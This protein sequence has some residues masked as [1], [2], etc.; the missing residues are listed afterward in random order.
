[1]FDGLPDACLTL[2]PNSGTLIYIGRGQ[3]GYYISNWDTGNPEQN[4]RIADEYNQKRGITKAQEE[5][6][7]N[8]SMFGWDTAAADPKRYESQPPLEINEGYAIIQR[9]S[10]GGIEIVL[11]ESTTSPDMYVTWRRTPAHEHHGKP[12]YYWGHYKND[13]N[14]A[15]TDFN[16][17]IE[18]EKMLIKESTEDKFRADTKKRHEPER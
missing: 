14:A 2:N 9:E 15:L 16:N 1:M 18:E 13:K 17:R 3:S 11:G 5:A 10:V 8:G 6:M 12:E 7:R 4:R